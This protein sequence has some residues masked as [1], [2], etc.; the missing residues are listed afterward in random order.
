MEIEN[1]LFA[2]ISHALYTITRYGFTNI[3]DYNAKRHEFQEIEDKIKRRIEALKV[4]E[5]EKHDELRKKSIL[6]LVKN[7]RN[8]KLGL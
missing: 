4:M 5:S 2:Y 8:R 1:F 3:N 7:K 6:F